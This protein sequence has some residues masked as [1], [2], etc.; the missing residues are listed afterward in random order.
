MASRYA[1]TN[2]ES[3]EW[4]AEDNDTFQYPT[5]RLLNKQARSTLSKPYEPSTNTHYRLLAVANT[6]GWFA[7]ARYNGS[8]YGAFVF[9][10]L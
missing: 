8:G 6:R 4:C 5:F 9:L 10:L 1:F 7:A 2:I 3:S